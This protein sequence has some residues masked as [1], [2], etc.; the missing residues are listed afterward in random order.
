MQDDPPDDEDDLSNMLDNAPTT[1]P[2]MWGFLNFSEAAVHLNIS[3]NAVRQLVDERKLFAIRDTSGLK[4]KYLELE[5]YI[6]DQ[7]DLDNPE[8]TKISSFK[9]PERG[10]PY[11]PDLESTHSTMLLDDDDY[12]TVQ[13]FFK[14]ILNQCKRMFCRLLLNREPYHFYGVLDTYNDYDSP[15]GRDSD[16]PELRGVEW[17]QKILK[18]IFRVFSRKKL[19]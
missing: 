9:C 11:L 19:P 8:D 16:P 1:P 2:N 13:P 7:S 5:R 17:L 3:E 18:K 6:E 10:W 12:G 4:F 14:R 15:L